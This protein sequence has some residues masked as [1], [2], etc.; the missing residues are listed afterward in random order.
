MSVIEKLAI[1]SD[2]ITK[3]MNFVIT[4]ELIKPDFDEYLKTLSAT[5]ADRGR[6]QAL[7][8]PYI[9]ER[10]LTEN[11][12][13][14]IQLF[15]DKNSDLSKEENEILE[16]LSKSFSSVYEIRRVLSNGFEMYN[17]VNE[18]MYKVLSL[19]KMNNFRGITPG[20]Y[21]LCRIFP[22]KDENYLLEI[23]NVLS[24]INKEEVYKY[25]I[26][27]IIERPEDAYEQNPKKLQ[28]IENLVKDFGEKFDKCFGKDEIITTNHYADN[29]INMFNEYCDNDIMP[30]KEA[31]EAN[32]KQVEN[33][34]YF[35]VSDFKNSYSDFMEKSLE[36]FSSHNSVYDIAIIY[37]KELGLFVLPFYQTFC[38]IYEAEDYKTVQGYKDCIKNFLENDK[39]PANIIKRV[40]G[41]YK[42]FMDRTNEILETNY[43]LDSLLSY[44]K[45]DSLEKKIFSSASVLYSSRIFELMMNYVSIKEESKEKQKEGID[46][47]HVGRN[48]KCPCGSGKKY[49]N[50]CMNKQ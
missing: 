41:K 26:A 27:K 12:K 33:N 43:T 1:I 3:V 14:I 38:K 16:C 34:R 8:I 6:L 30:V 4:D 48:D 46:Y 31:I 18:R 42:N 25:A 35:T 49:K 40:A 7:L 24:S 13:T 37:D 29:I 36:G 23:S 20:Q 45:A 5:N 2:T 39:V 28:Q 19:V 21:A 32:I 44:Y 11:R 50:C 9:F 10:R 22:M 47:S 17:L 15:K